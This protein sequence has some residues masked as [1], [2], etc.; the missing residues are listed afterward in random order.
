MNPKRIILILASI[1][2]VS[3]LFLD[4]THWRY[5]IGPLH[6]VGL[7]YPFP[8]MQARLGMAEGV[9]EGIDVNREQN[10][11]TGNDILNNKPLYTLHVLSFFNLGVEDVI[12]M[13]VFFGCAFML[14]NFYLLRPERWIEL[15]L[16]TMV[17]LSPPVLL[18][19]QRGNDDIIVYSFILSVP[20]L[21]MMKS[22]MGQLA[23][24]AVIGFLT[25]VK[26]FPAAAY[27][28]FLYRELLRRFVVIT[29]GTL[30][31]GLFVYLCIRG[32]LESSLLDR[33]PSPPIS[34]SIGGVAFFQS[35]ILT[36][37]LAHFCAW[38][39]FLVLLGSA[40][41]FALRSRPLKQTENIK[42]NLYFILGFS[43][44]AFCFTF[45]N[46]WDYRLAFLVPTLPLMTKWLRSKKTRL[47]LLTGLYLLPLLFV[48]WSEYLFFFSVFDPNSGWHFNKV[49]HFRIIRIRHGLSW[50]LFGTGLHILALLM[51]S[52]APT[53]KMLFRKQNKPGLEA[54]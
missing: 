24:W 25:P 4:H 21:L 41:I 44:F 39:A 52:H 45:N 31:Y 36:L 6:N 34:T 17:L 37:E 14:W 18:L 10:P 32:E 7:G 5:A 28:L 53:L 50:V 26:Y 29:F 15:C 46:N 8:D 49:E 12:P 51:F 9:A 47:M 35:F 19:F 3:F 48:L 42:E 1:A 13:G 40:L 27:V 23:G 20:L 30:V 33:I 22:R 54:S 2:L 16:H 38:A 43:L 11:Y